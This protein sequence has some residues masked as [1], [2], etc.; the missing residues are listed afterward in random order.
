[1]QCVS[2]CWCIAEQCRGGILKFCDPGSSDRLIL[3]G[4]CTFRSSFMHFSPSL[5]QDAKHDPQMEADARSWLEAIAGEPFPDGSFHE[6][7]KDGVYLCKVIN[8]LEPGSVPKINQSKMAF[9]MVTTIIACMF[10]NM[11]VFLLC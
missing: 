3:N 4:F 9:K 11:D 8:Q 7:L 5:Q 6:A 1:M 2:V 10:P